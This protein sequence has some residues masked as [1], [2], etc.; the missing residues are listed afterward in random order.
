MIEGI[1]GDRL[2]KR[3]GRAFK[4]QSSLAIKKGRRYAIIGPNGSGKST[5]LRIMSLLELPD[6]GTVIYHNSGDE[7]KNPFRDLSMRRKVVLLPTRASL[8][9]DTLFNNVSYGLRVRGMGKKMMRERI[10][11]AL[12]DVGL[13]GK[14][15][16]HAH[17]LSSGEAQRLALARALILNPQVLFLDE[18]TAS[19]DPASTKIVEERILTWTDKSAGICVIV[20]HNLFQARRLSDE[21]I[22]LYGGNV[23]EATETEQ[24]FQSPS[25]EL[26][27]KF[28]FGEIY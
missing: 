28:V 3:Y 18:P 16:D 14:M 9:N 20:T 6:S 4:L 27:R 17:T 2:E 5:L 11:E 21:V 25:T 7:L 1:R 19:L 13:R 10:V 23:I 24:F 15:E 8:F 26:G 12:E 22:F